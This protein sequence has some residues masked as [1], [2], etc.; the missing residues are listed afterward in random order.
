MD[1]AELI[2]RCEASIVPI[3]HWHDR[4]SDSTQKGVGTLWA[5]LKCGASFQVLTRETPCHPDNEWAVRNPDKDNTGC[6][7]D[8]DTIWVEIKTESFMHVESGETVRQDFDVF[9]LPTDKRLK[10]AAGKDWY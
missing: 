6:Y 5:Y 1:R 10:K 9:Y 7:T 2:A 4:D 8:D 3:E